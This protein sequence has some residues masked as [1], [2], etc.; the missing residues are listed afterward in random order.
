[1]PNY[2][3]NSVV[4]T[5]TE[6]QLEQVHGLFAEIQRL[7]ELNGRFHLPH[8]AAREQGHMLDIRFD[9]G[10]ILYE[11]RWVPNT[12]RLVEIADFYNAGFTSR[13]WEMANGLYGTAGYDLE[14]IYVVSINSEDWQ[15][16]CYDQQLKG[17]P[18]NGDV[19]EYEGDLLDR[20]LEEKKQSSEPFTVV[21]INRNY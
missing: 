18:H 5:G 19:F 12:A 17:Y 8:F 7:Q 11:T 16:V 6:K 10:S 2:C 1:M 15:K 3:S 20:I 9:R 13:Y 14:K 21:K 4:F